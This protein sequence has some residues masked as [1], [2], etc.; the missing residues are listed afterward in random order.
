M[1]FWGGFSTPLYEQGGET[2]QKNSNTSEEKDRTATKNNGYDTN[3]EN[4]RQIIKLIHVSNKILLPRRKFNEILLVK[5]VLFARIINTFNCNYTFH[6]L[7][8]KTFIISLRES[9]V[10]ALADFSE[11]SEIVFKKSRVFTIS[12]CD[13]ECPRRGAGGVI[14][15]YQYL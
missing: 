13:P 10:T 14:G 6:V 9:L 4:N 8:N 15:W 7:S 11:K 1:L 3:D 5:C 2:F 12:L